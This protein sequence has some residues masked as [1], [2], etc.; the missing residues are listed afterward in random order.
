MPKYSSTKK[1]KLTLTLVVGAYI[2]ENTT[3]KQVMSASVGAGAGALIGTKI[4][5][6]ALGTAVP[7]VWPLAVVFGVIGW[8]AAR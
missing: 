7:G 3:A 1:F 4:G 5:I 6:A 2:K 8:L